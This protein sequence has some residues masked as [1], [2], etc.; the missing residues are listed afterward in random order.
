MHDRPQGVI[1]LIA[2]LCAFMVAGCAGLPGPEADLPT[3]ASASAPVAGDSAGAATAGGSTS[4]RQE[5]AGP[6]ALDAAVSAGAG[7][8]SA[9]QTDG[10]LFLES[11]SLPAGQT[12]PAATLKQVMAE[13]QQVGAFDPAAQA[14]L[15]SDLQQTDPALWPLMVRQFRAALAYR[16]SADSPSPPGRAVEGAQPHAAAF[17]GQTTLPGQGGACAQGPGCL[18]G[19][20]YP[21]GPLGAGLPGGAGGVEQA[22]CQ[23]T[24]V[25]QASYQ[26]SG[27]GAAGAQGQWPSGASPGSAAPASAPGPVHVPISAPA[28]QHLATGQ[29][30]AESSHAAAASGPPAQSAAAPARQHD[31]RTHL[32]SAILALESGLHGR[33][34][35]PQAL[36]DQARLRML[37]L[38]AGQRDGALRPISGATPAVQD[39]WIKQLYGL[40]TWLDVE[41]EPD[42]GRRAGEAKQTLGEALARLRELAPLMVRNLAFCTE[43]QSFGCNTPFTSYEFTPGQPVLLYA[44]VDNF[45][46]EPTPKGYHTALR[47]RYRI[48]DTQGR[49]VEDQ[50]FTLTEEYCRNQR[51]DFFIGYHLGLPE[52][53]APG[54]YTL[55]L[56]IEDLKSNKVGQ[57]SVELSIRGTAD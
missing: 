45:T 32:S 29:A 21:P 46:S 50:D 15:L 20:S 39:F 24:G 3:H 48:F 4:V 18:A 54:R 56:T 17:S 12:A 25:Q 34:T 9:D 1:L 26:T 36:A 41:R 43:I 55:E 14:R 51:C 16:R 11:L 33:G 30:P 10:G 22:P 47:S 13:L 7:Q 28:P 44:E 35:E 52:Q 5:A 8:G 53:L 31:W 40:G 49:C 27:T 37:C 38:A 42:E 2:G 57:S 6:G 23:T 19:P